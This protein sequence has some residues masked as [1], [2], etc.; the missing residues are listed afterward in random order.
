MLHARVAILSLLLVAVIAVPSE[1]LASASQFVE[2]EKF[3][4]L[5]YDGTIVAR[6][7]ESSGSRS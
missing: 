1:A 2:G 7:D 6:V 4:L 5:L 3:D